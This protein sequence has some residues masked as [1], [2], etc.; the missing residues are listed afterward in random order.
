MRGEI[1]TIFQS[2]SEGPRG[3]RVLGRCQSFV[4]DASVSLA[5]GDRQVLQNVTVT[6]GQANWGGFFR[7]DTGS[8]RCIY[9]KMQLLVLPTSN[10]DAYVR[11]PAISELEK[12]LLIYNFLK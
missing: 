3:R 1:T 10:Q 5:E 9:M 4:S 2:L 6:T 7:P 8:Q 12:R 11:L